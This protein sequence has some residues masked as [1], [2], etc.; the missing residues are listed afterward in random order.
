MTTKINDI[1]EKILDIID[2]VPQECIERLIAAWDSG[3]HITKYNMPEMVGMS[4]EKARTLMILVSNPL[5]QQSMLHAMFTAGL[6]ARRRNSSKINE[7]EIVWTGPS[8]VSAGIRNTKPV[9]EEM[10]KSARPGE[11][12]T[13]IDYMITSNAESIIRQLNSCLDAG[14]DVDLIIDKSQVNERELGRCFS[15]HGLTRPTIYTRK[16]EQHGFYKVH[17]KVIIIQD[18]EMLVSSANL[19]ELGTEVN[20]EIGLFV[21][22]R[23][24]KNM[25]TLISKM[26]QNGYFSRYC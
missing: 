26:I 24:V 4:G 23:I 9:I 1:S 5:I 7:V 25:A 6:G 12:V 2:N 17:A 18:R 3:R 13:I 11:K 21:R 8:S 20:F 10:L 19:T 16:D 15:I 14:I 22:G